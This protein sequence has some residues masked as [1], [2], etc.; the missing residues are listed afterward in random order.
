MVKSIDCSSEGHEFKS[1]QSWLP[2]LRE[3]VFTLL[4]EHLPRY[5]ELA[6]TTC[7]VPPIIVTLRAALKPRGGELVP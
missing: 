6:G 3:V 7:P 4:G 1:F 2:K 5:H